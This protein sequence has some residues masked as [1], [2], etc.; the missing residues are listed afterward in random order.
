MIK[1]TN[2]LIICLVSCFAALSID[3]LSQINHGAIVMKGGEVPL[4]SCT[5]QGVELE[6]IWPESPL[7]LHWTWDWGDGE[8]GHG[9]TVRH[10]YQSEGKFTIL[11]SAIA[12]SETYSLSETITIHQTIVPEIQEALLCASTPTWLKVK[13]GEEKVAIEWS[14]GG[15]IMFGD[16]VFFLVE[17]EGNVNVLMKMSDRNGCL[18]S[19]ETTV[20][21]RPVPKADFDWN[22]TGIKENEVAF[23]ERSEGANLMFEWSFGQKKY[24]M[25]ADPIVVF[26]NSEMQE[27]K[28]KVFNTSGCSAESIKEIIAQSPILDIQARDMQI[29]TMANS[30][31]LHT[32]IKNNGNFP[33]MELGIECMAGAVTIANEK[34]TGRLMPGMEAEIL[35]PIVSADLLAEDI[36][37]SI[38]AMGNPFRE[39]TPEDNVI[40]RTTGD[41]RLEVYPPFPNPGDNHLFLRFIN[42]ER[43]TVNI[44]ITDNYGSIVQ[45]LLDA[46]VGTGFHQYFLN[47]GDLANGKYIIVL[48]IG[49]IKK[50]VNFIKV[51]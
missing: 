51:G 29:E 15:K 49:E 35:T 37:L 20:A 34:W 7:G 44:T 38:S 47:I 50:A 18:S 16:S 46:D 13:E 10:T 4:H 36:C 14:F 31:S 5:G 28:L 27:V 39:S 9:I 22:I 12:G 21:V 17:K 11:A 48:G 8:K 40:C 41:K 19:R 42:K 6:I 2:Y 24:S 1:E 26:E 43:G 3:C 33:L 30:L 23:Y 32:K 25:E 45:E